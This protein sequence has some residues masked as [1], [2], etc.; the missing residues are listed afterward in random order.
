M[1]KK[2]TKPITSD[3]MWNQCIL[4]GEK[5]FGSNWFCKSCQSNEEL[6][7]SRNGRVLPYA[8][9]PEYV[10]F[11]KNEVNANRMR[12]SRKQ[13]IEELPFSD[14]EIQTEDNESFYPAVESGKL[15]S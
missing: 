15:I 9:W 1:R 7:I 6:G 8:Q 12:Q 14:F 5:P 13:T 3:A 2:Y 11:L 4:C 10:R